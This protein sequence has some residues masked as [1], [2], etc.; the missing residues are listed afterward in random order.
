[1]Q[2]EATLR[3]HP[4]HP[5]VRMAK[6]NKQRAARAGEDVECGQHSFIVGGVQTGEATM[7]ISVEVSQEANLH[8]PPWDQNLSQLLALAVA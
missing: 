4:S 6:I 7:E 5:P 1:M 2:S 8:L 3:L